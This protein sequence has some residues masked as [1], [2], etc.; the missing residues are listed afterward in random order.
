M[1]SKMSSIQKRS[2]RYVKKQ[3][4]MAHIQEEKRVNKTVPEDAQMLDLFNKDF[5][6]I[7]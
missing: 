7:L 4:S 3:E 2:M 5:N 1:L 6:Q